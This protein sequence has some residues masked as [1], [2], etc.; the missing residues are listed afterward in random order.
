MSFSTEGLA[1]RVPFIR[2]GPSPSWGAV[3]LVSFVVIA[4]LLGNALTT[5]GDVTSNPS[6]SSGGADPGRASR[7]SRRRVRSS[8]CA[9]IAT[10]S[11]TPRSRRRCGA[12]RARRRRSA[13]SRTRRATTP[14]TTSRSS[15]RIATRRWC[16]SSMR[17]DEV[18]PLVELVEVG[19]REERLP[20]L[21]HR[22]ADGR[23]RLREALGGRPAERRAADRPAGGVDR[24][25]A[26][27]R[28]RRRGARPGA[29][30]TAVD[31]GRGRP[32]RA[33]RPGVRGLVLRREHDLG[34]GA[35]ARDRL[36]ALHPLALPRGARP[37]AR[38]DRRDRRVGS[39]GEPRRPLQRDGLRARDVRDAARARHD[40]AQPRR[41]AR[42][43]SA[44]SR[45]SRR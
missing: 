6:R 8:S 7:P 9:R 5:D 22:L 36:L 10:P 37:R 23:R 27:L 25:A 31:R 41:S 42:S 32:D 34:D 16:R 26:R 29:A 30:R 1:V 35:R 4:L 2:S 39:D 28:R 13:S 43:S 12:R 15:R 44:S 17:G 3:V 40:P 11:T 20:D 21:D 24:A 18:A 38:E 33:R 19:E 14:R 45:C